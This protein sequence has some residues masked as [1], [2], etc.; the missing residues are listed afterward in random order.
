MLQTARAA[1]Y[2]AGVI[3]KKHYGRTLN[4][5]AESANDIKLE[6]DR[7]C[8]AAIVN[9]IRQSFPAHAILAE[10]GGARGGR[11]P[12]WIIDPLDGTVNYF[13]GLPYFC[14]S[15]ACFD[16]A[17]TEGEILP[18]LGKPLFGV[19]YAPITGDLF[20]AEAGNGAFLNDEPVRAAAVDSLDKAMIA[21]GF[22][23]SLDG[24][25]RMRT[26]SEALYT[27]VRKMRC[28]GAAAYD[29][30]NVAAGRLSGF[31]ERGLHHWDVA[32]ASVI[33]FEAGAQISARE[34]SPGC[35]DY[36]AS[37]PGIAEEFAQSLAGAG[38]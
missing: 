33:A 26:G 24:L 4:V 10:E 27:R 17:C 23:S 14:T 28:L 34:L 6:V 30:C 21:T 16:T 12:T 19:V 7:L 29:I 8:E 5:D 22:G 38:E 11:G 9:T 36:V 18:G 3:Q 35:W 31:F 37:A 32:A 2:A 15:I 13:H 20:C 25:R 1:A